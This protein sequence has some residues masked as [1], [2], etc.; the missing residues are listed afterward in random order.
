MG[1]SL[2][3]SG[4]TEVSDFSEVLKEKAFLQMHADD[5]EQVE[6]ETHFLFPSRYLQCHRN[7]PDHTDLHFCS[8]NFSSVQG[9]GEDLANALTSGLSTE[10]PCLPVFSQ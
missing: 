4:L 7:P 5:L 10:G 3:D 1:T 6:P 2:A 9:A 8:A